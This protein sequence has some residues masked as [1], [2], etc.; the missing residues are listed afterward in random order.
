M[1]M[2]V[3][4]FKEN[5]AEYE[6]KLTF[7]N[8]DIFPD[9]KDRLYKLLQEKWDIWNMPDLEKGITVTVEVNERTMLFKG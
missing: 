9:D 2:I 3:K 8:S 1:K 6:M 7:K 4:K 5:F